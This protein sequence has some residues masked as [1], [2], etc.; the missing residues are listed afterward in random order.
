MENHQ[1]CNVVL[2]PGGEHSFSLPNKPGYDE[3]IAHSAK[4]TVLDIFA[5]V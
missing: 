5:S 3:A 1:H 4:Q 2:H